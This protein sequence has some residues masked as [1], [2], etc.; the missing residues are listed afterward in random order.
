[1]RKPST[2]DPMPAKSEQVSQPPAPAAPVRLLK[3]PGVRDRI[4]V[5][6]S[7]LW[8]MIQRGEFKKPVRLTGN[9]VAWWEDDVNDWIE[10]RSKR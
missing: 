2:R 8:R 3:F 5:S 1:M 4:P 9:S 7:T 6:R 10:Q